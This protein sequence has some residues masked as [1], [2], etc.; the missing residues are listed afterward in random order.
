MKLFKKI[1]AF[2]LAASLMFCTSA[3]NASG[4]VPV[5][6]NI[7]VEKI[8][9]KNPDFIRGMDVSSV[10][11]LEKAGVRF[12]N[13]DGET[14][15]IFKLLSDGG[16]NY[17][18]VRV[19]NDPYDGNGKGY[20]GGNNDLEAAAEIGR[21]AAE[22]GMKL[23]VDFHYSDFWADPSKQKAPKEWSELSL[24]EKEVRSR[25]KD[26]MIIGCRTID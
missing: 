16:V 14:E 20:G 23:L 4:E 22:N 5:K 24:S 21:R 9:F 10:I 13:A 6:D 2:A 15:D 12:K 17:I 18:R 25:R 19:W 3:A 7:K 11:S 8:E 1:T 26:N